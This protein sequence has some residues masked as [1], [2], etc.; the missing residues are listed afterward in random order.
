MRND[1]EHNLIKGKIAETIFE[2]MFREVKKFTV[3]HFGYEYT[4]S[5]LAQYQNMV[6]MRKVL[7]TVSKAPDFILLTENKKQ[8]Y[9]VEVKYR[10]HID[11]EEMVSIAEQIVKNWEIA[12][13]FLISKEG[14]HFGPVHRIINSNG[15][16]ED[17][18]LGWVSEKIQNKYKKLA[19]DWLWRHRDRN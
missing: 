18:R 19:E 8:P 10:A 1:F 17:L 5:V 3:L 2:M 13:I 6:V 9:I 7:D 16:I 14:F 11:K 4:E 12:W 15:Q